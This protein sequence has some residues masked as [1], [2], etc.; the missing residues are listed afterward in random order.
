MK[1]SEAVAKLLDNFVKYLKKQQALDKLV[2]E[3]EGA[4][5]TSPEEQLEMVRNKLL[6]YEF[7][8]DD[9]LEVLIRSKGI[10]TEK[11]EKDVIQRIKEYIKALIEISR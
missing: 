7:Y 11:L 9:G 5:A 10:N 6:P 1:K 2:S 4:L 3:Y 8:I